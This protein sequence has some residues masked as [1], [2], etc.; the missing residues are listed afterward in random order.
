MFVAG[1]V[2]KNKL[3]SKLATV[4]DVLKGDMIRVRFDGDTGTVELHA[5]RFQAHTGPNFEQPFEHVDPETFKKGDYIQVTDG[6]GVT[7]KGAALTELNTSGYATFDL[8][9]DDGRY[10]DFNNNYV[11]VNVLFRADIARGQMP[12]Y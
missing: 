8:L 1:D 4:T 6:N 7:V 3:N 11:N 10:L 5:S 12:A 2:V 9:T